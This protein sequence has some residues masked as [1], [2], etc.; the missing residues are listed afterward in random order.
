MGRDV[1]AV[2]F[3]WER[4]HFKERSWKRKQKYST[5]SISLDASYRLYFQYSQSTT[6]LFRLIRPH[7][8]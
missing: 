5:V 8:V 2:K 1:E 4:K 3:L 6:V 7:Q